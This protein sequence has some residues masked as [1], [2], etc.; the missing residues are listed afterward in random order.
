MNS[1]R[2]LAFLRRHRR[3]GIDT[4]PFVF[5]LEEHP[6]YG[7]PSDRLFRWVHSGRS[8]GITSTVTMTEVL[9]LP[10]RQGRADAANNSFSTLVQMGNIEWLS[11]SLG[12]ADRA[13]RA[14]AMYNLRTLDALQLATALTAGATGFITNDQHFRRVPDLEVLMLDDLFA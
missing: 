1:A 2:L 4:S 12:V 13:A 10:Y 6:T 9:V 8:V 11:P 7:A 3:L 5:H 14:R